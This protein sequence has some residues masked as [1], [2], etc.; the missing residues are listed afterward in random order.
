[1]EYEEEEFDEEEDYPGG[2]GEDDDDE[3]ARALGFMYNIAHGYP[4]INYFYLVYLF[5]TFI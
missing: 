5:G 2:E 4:T 3:S 1:M